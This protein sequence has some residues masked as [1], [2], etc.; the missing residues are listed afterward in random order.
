MAPPHET[1]SWGP[2]RYWPTPLVS[3]ALYKASGVPAIIAAIARLIGHSVAE[4]RILP[5][6]PERISDSTRDLLVV[7]GR[8]KAPWFVS[9]LEI[10]HA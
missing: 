8:L 2:D 4:E 5:A 3:Q 10:F 1:S 9:L 7:V 6:L